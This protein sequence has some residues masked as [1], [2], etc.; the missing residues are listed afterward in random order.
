MDEMEHQLKRELQKSVECV[1]DRMKSI[2]DRMEVNM[3][4]FEK[5][6]KYVATS[7]PYNVVST[8]TTIQPPAYDGQTPLS[9][10]NKQFK[11]AA[12]ANL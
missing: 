1:E 7:G 5:I 8:P 9:P 6:I 4:K 11:A 10:Y 12:T 2:E 3:Q